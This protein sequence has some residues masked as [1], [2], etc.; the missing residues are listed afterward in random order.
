MNR[1]GLF[2]HKVTG[3]WSIFHHNDEKKTFLQKNVSTWAS[4][5]LN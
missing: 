3:N 1:G 2:L 4:A 5:A